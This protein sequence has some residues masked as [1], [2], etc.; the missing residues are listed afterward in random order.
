MKEEQNRISGLIIKAQQGDKSA[1]EELYNLTRHISLLSKF[2]V[3]S[4]MHRIFCRKA[5]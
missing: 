2:A 3:T 1:F 4:T 5:I